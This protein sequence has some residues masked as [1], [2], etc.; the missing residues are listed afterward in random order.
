[1]SDLVVVE[2]IEEN[3]KTKQFV[4]IDDPKNSVFQYDENVKYVI[5]FKDLAVFENF[6]F[7][8]YSLPEV[9]I[10]KDIDSNKLIHIYKNI[11]NKLDAFFEHPHLRGGTKVDEKSPSIVI[12]VLPYVIADLGELAGL[13]I[14]VT[15]RIRY[16]TNN[17]QALYKLGDYGYSFALNTLR[18]ALFY[19]RCKIDAYIKCASWNTAAFNRDFKMINKVLYDR[20]NGMF[21][22]D[23]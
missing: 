17:P 7:S 1:M 23:Y 14:S 12:E 4:I 3:C 16:V 18:E 22:F 11:R 6:N 5:P 8:V 9:D 20:V 13:L 2:G 10:Y 21:H 19:F 15:D